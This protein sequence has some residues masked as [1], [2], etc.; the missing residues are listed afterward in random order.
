[1]KKE[2]VRLTYPIK[3]ACKDGK[4]NYLFPKLLDLFA[5]TFI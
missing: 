4:H 1:M 5:D 2:F 3:E